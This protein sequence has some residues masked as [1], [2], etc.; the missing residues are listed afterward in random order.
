M[1]IIKVKVFPSCSWRHMEGVDLWLRSFLISEIDG[2]KV[3]LSRLCIKQIPIFR[4]PPEISKYTVFIFTVT[5]TAI[6]MRVGMNRSK[7][8]EAGCW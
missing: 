6:T 3:I 7:L 4:Q 8:H 2:A 5:A 1:I